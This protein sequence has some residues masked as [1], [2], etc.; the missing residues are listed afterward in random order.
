MRRNLVY[1]VR[2]GYV[3]SGS[4]IRV[5]SDGYYWSQVSRSTL[6]YHLGF[7]SSYVYPSDGSYRLAGIPLRCVAIGS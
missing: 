6:A 7:G 2:G 1:F 5:G 3:V 4:L